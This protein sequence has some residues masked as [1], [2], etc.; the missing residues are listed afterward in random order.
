M[1]RGAGLHR[2]L[3]S[4]PHS[5][6]ISA[7]STMSP[8]TRESML[9]P[10]PPAS[11]TSLRMAGGSWVWTKQLSSA[12]ASWGWGGVGQLF[13]PSFFRNKLLFSSSVNSYN[14]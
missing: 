1:W 2:I 9:A 14:R 13:C 5:V 4:S 12:S 8:C 3:G 11:L 10:V 6:Q 7:P